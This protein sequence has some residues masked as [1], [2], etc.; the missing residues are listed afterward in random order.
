MGSN[1]KATVKAAKTR[2]EKDTKT[3]AHPS[4]AQ[5]QGSLA[6]RHIRT[7]TPDSLYGDQGQQ[8]G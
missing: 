6:D 7:H 1:K 3:I 5:T 4:P 2:V 8:Q